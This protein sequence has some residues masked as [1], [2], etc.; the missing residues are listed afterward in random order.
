MKLLVTF[1]TT[2]DSLKAEQSLLSEGVNIRIRPIPR[3]ISSD[4]GLC[5][6]G[7]EGD[8]ERILDCLY[9]SEVEYDKIHL[10]QV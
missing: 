3:H 7:D 10:V 9:K 1:N 4:C 6:E 2:F 8:R 5:I